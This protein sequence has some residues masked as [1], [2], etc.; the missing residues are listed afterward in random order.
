MT[1]VGCVFAVDIPVAA[2]FSCLPHSHPCTEILVYHACQGWLLEAGQRLAYRPGILSISPPPQ[3]HS[4]E[5]ETAGIHF[6]IGVSGCGSEQLPLMMI[7]VST[8]LSALC[9]DIRL[10]ARTTNPAP[11]EELD[12]LAGLLVLELRKIASPTDK[13]P[14]SHRKIKQI[15]G[16]LDNEYGRP[17]RI[18]D[19]AAAVFLSPDYL[20]QS[21]KE[22]YGYSPMQ[23]L[24]KKRIDTACQM[25]ISSNAPVKDIAERC[26]IENVFYFSRLFKK[27][28]GKTPTQ[29]RQHMR[30]PEPTG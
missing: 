8:K 29:Y 26:G 7:P 27:I 6:C 24:L 16:V 30:R 10:L 21:F 9:N 22:A 15:K 17:M 3:D 12:L 11:A 28:T 25:M 23:Y 4:V 2:G 14:D 5:N 19:L 20:R 13:E 18:K 1:T